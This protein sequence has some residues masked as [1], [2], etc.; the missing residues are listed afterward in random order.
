[1]PA[2]AWIWKGR[3]PRRERW[4]RVRTLATD[5]FE[6]IIKLLEIPGAFVPGGP[7]A[8]QKARALSGADLQISALDSEL[9][10][11]PLDG[12]PGPFESAVY[13]EPVFTEGVQLSVTVSHDGRGEEQILLE[14]LDLH[15][16]DF[17][18]ER[19][20]EYEARL[21]GQAIHGAGA[22]L[23]D[24]LRFFVELD[25]PVVGRA[26]RMERAADGTR[27]AL[28]ADSANFLDTDPGS[29]VAMG[30]RDVQMK[31]RITIHAN[32]PGLYR[33]CLRW[34]Y[35]V[36]ARELRQHTSLPFALYKAPEDA[37]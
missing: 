11:M 21:E 28:V 14:R 13:D 4:A 5:V 7:E 31:I 20:P 9:V 3:S 26:R 34:F 15:V 25:G 6:P 27:K 16:V 18:R 24:P 10:M 32:T 36:A 8:L 23:I 30:P 35:R 17:D 37:S 2:S 19:H 29:Y 22:V 33:V 12:A 1:M